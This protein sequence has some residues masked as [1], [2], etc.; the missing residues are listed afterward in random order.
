MIEKKGWCNDD[1]E[2][3]GWTAGSDEKTDKNQ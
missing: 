1:G 2:T 3:G